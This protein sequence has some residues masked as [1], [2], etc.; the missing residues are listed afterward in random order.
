MIQVKITAVR[1][2]RSAST[3]PAQEPRPNIGRLLGRAHIELV[4][5]VH[6]RLDILGFGD[7]RPAHEP[8]FQLIDAGGTRVTELAMRAGISK[9]AMTELVAHLESGGYLTRV[10][11]PSDG[12]AKLVVITERGWECIAAA[13]AVVAEVEGEWR[14]AMGADRYAE[15]HALLRDL[16]AKLSGEQASRPLGPAT[17]GPRGNPATPA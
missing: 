3:I 6:A 1:H 13:R 5:A 15:L 2:P 7:V 14:Q 8:V 4:A 9:Q 17:A 12:R 11:D 10:P 16:D